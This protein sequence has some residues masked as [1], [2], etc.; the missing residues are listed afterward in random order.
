M[1]SSVCVRERGGEKHVKEWSSVA[2]GEKGKDYL[3][4]GRKHSPPGEE[5][6]FESGSFFSLSRRRGFLRPRGP[7][8][9]IGSRTDAKNDARP[10]L[11][12][13][14]FGGRVCDRARAWTFFSGEAISFKRSTTLNAT[15]RRTSFPAFWFRVWA[16]EQIR[17][18]SHAS[19]QIILDIRDFE[20]RLVSHAVVSE[21]RARWSRYSKR[22]YRI[23]L[24]FQWISNSRT[25]SSSSS[26]GRIVSN[27]RSL[28]LCVSRSL[29]RAQKHALSGRRRK[30]R[31]LQTGCGLFVT[32]K[33]GTFEEG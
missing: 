33:A 29:A 31:S 2:R 22:F 9:R 26:E 7:S 20:V 32:L 4:V 8:R 10:T 11:L 13:A 6:P 23:S 28:S 3:F 1:V 25:P 18:V 5:R 14:R 16:H 17:Q 24:L 12:K 19:Q 27:A 30:R 15:R 21:R